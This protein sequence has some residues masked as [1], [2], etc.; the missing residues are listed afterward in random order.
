MQ[1]I[2]IDT[3]LGQYECVADCRI[4]YGESWYN[5]GRCGSAFRPQM[6]FGYFMA[7]DPEE[8]FFDKKV[9]W[10]LEGF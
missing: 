1:R 5:S 6:K 7:I 10:K 8:E 9:D 2:T 3:G 4:H